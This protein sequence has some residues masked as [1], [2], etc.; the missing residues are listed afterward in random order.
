MLRKVLSAAVAVSLMS[1]S[2]LA[3]AGQMNKFYVGADYSYNMFTTN[4]A[5]EKSY[6][7]PPSTFMKRHL[8]GLTLKGGY[9]WTCLGLEIGHTF[10]QDVKYKFANGTIDQKNY[11]NYID[12]YYYHPLMRNLDV[13]A[14]V[15]LGALTTKMET[16]SS[17]TIN[18]S[19]FTFT[20]SSHKEENYTSI[21]PRAGVGLQYY[22]AKCLSADVMYKYQSGNKIYSNMNTV[23]VGVNLHI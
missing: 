10:M 17:S 7:T 14:M 20:T 19:F 18:G 1:V 6:I 11:N 23:A 5:T 13:K 22:F 4:K 2:S 3:F 16:N 9:R 12:A 8:N 21:K 15:G